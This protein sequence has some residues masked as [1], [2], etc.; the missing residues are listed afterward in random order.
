MGAALAGAALAT[1]AAPESASPGT[2]S[3]LG[4]SVRPTVTAFAAQA[5]G[6]PLPTAVGG[7]EAGGHLVAVAVQ[8]G[9]L[10]VLRVEPLEQ[11]QTA[12]GQASL[13]LLWNTSGGG[14]PVRWVWGIQCCCMAC[15]CIAFHELVV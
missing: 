2:S 3:W 11:A 14:S 9:A 7:V 13:C 5:T 10:A 15:G 6:T 12:P 4:G 1:A 8:G